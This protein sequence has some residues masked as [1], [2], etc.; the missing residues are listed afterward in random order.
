MARPLWTPRPGKTGARA[1]RGRRRKEVAERNKA[2][3][4]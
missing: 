3:A 4:V 1:T 2:E